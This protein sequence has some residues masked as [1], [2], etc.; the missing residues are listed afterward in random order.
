MKVL[1]LIDW[2]QM[3]RTPQCLG[4]LPSF[5]SGCQLSGGSVI[6]M[7]KCVSGC[8]VQRTVNVRM[9]YT[10]GGTLL[11]PLSSNDPKTLI[12]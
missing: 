4:C 7:P 5:P 10:S 8:D 12:P 6:F 3:N 2:Q 1:A 11:C 9:A